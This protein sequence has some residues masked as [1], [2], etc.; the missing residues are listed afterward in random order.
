VRHRCVDGNHDIHQ[1]QQR[2][3]IREIRQVAALVPDRTQP[4]HN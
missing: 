2:R 1:R 4:R 3:G